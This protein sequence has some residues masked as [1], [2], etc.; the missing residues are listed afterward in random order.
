MTNQYSKIKAALTIVGHTNWCP[1]LLL[2][3]VRPLQIATLK[4]WSNISRNFSH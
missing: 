4:N 3:F 2:L 1:L